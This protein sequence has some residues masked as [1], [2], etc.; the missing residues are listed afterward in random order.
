[1]TTGELQAL[2]VQIRGYYG[3]RFSDFSPGMVQLWFESL[4]HLDE[5]LCIQGLKRWARQHNFKVPSLDE[6]LEQ[7]EIVRDEQRRLA[8][9][10]GS[11]T[12]SWLD[13]LRD[14]QEN[15]QANPL[16]SEDDVTYGQLMALLAERSIDKWQ[17]KQGVWHD[18]LTVEQRGEQCYA[19]ATAYETRRPEL[20][21]DLRA[22]ARKFGEVLY[23]QAR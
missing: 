7:I 9:R 10:D 13:A 18:K 23:V 5:E 17:D 15:E 20:A 19:W 11:S 6:L 4:H 8:R 21:Q 16:R 22:A 2:M 3:D 12:K 14:A 1:M